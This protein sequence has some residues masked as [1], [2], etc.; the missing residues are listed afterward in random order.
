MFTYFFIIFIG[1][2][3]VDV[4]VSFVGVTGLSVLCGILPESLKLCG[5]CKEHK[6]ARTEE[7]DDKDG[8][9]REDPIQH[10]DSFPTDDRMT[11]LDTDVDSKS[12]DFISYDHF[13]ENVEDTKASAWVVWVRPSGNRSK[14]VRPDQCSKNDTVLDAKDWRVLSRKLVKYGIRTGTYKCARDTKLCK[15]HGIESCSVLLS[16]PAGAKPK[17]RVATYLYRNK[18]SCNMQGGRVKSRLCLLEWIKSK[19]KSKVLMLSRTEDLPTFLKRSKSNGNE[20]AAKSNLKVIYESGSKFP[21]LLMSALSVRFTGRIKFVQMKSQRKKEPHPFELSSMYL[22]TLHSNYSYGFRKGEKFHYSNLDMFL[23]TLHPEANDIF[24][25]TLIIINMCCMFELFVQK[26]GPLR[27]LICFTWMAFI[28]NSLLIFT[29]LPI[30]RVLQ[31]P[32]TGPLIEFL[33]K[34]LQVVMFSDVAAMVRK[35]VLLFSQHI[36]MFCFGLVLY[37]SAVGYL[38]FVISNRGLPR[39]TLTSVWAED[40]D[41]VKEF[42]RSLVT[43]ASPPLF[44]YELE[45]RLENLL[46]RLSMPDL[47][48]H[49]LHSSQYVRHL[50]CW[51]FCRK[52]CEAPVSKTSKTKHS[53]CKKQNE[54]CTCH[55]QKC[56]IPHYAILCVDCVV[57]LENYKCGEI[58][59]MLPCGHCFHKDCIDCWLLQSCDHN[60]KKCPVCRWPANK[61]KYYVSYNEYY[62]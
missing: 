33:L 25:L 19:L 22:L 16:M 55:L 42:F 18:S 43:L 34:T 45:E 6:N 28:S 60:N 38:R 49:P 24:L 26:G 4:S 39:P 5:L 15:R 9:T 20:M 30:M 10:G 13:L 31:F 47:W 37:G 46:Q 36:G 59:K 21:P 56:K 12:V 61:Q 3:L 1:S 57:C 53:A 44:Y 54:K 62:E 40:L 35:D 23:R 32:E 8:R 51:K 27:R 2:R 52:L 7:T 29:W 41:E 17:G 48:L 58:V 50:V 11:S 14:H